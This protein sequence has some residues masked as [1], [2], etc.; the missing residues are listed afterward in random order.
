MLSFW[1][2]QLE[3]HEKDEAEINGMKQ[4][5]VMGCITKL[6]MKQGASQIGFSCQW[7]SGISGTVKFLYH[8]YDQSGI[9]LI[10]VNNGNTATACEI[11]K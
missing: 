1:P 5:L 6:C 10:K 3:N 2:S 8:N 11:R 7:K 4:D 9:F